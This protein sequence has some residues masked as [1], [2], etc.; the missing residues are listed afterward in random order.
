MADEPPTIRLRFAH[1]NVDQRSGTDAFYS[2][3]KANCCVA[4]G[5]ADNYL[6]YKVKL[7]Y[8]I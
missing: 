2:E 5:G 1:K 7:C 8:R 3:R 6:R 4:C